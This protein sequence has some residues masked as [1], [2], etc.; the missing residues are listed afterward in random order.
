MWPKPYFAVPDG[1]LQCCRIQINY[2][3][4]GVV[5]PVELDAWLVYN[6]AGE[7]AKYDA[8]FRWFAWTVDTITQLLAANSQLGL[9][10]QPGLAATLVDQICA[11]ND[12]YC[13][14]SNQQYA[15]SSDCTSFLSSIEIG[16]SYQLGFNTLACRSLHIHMLP[17]RP[18][19]HCPHIGE[20]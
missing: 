12:Q 18:S 1:V 13:T 14:G 4:L 20:S 16:E 2:T 5:L 6:D 15:N 17:L 3:A 19:V 9:G 7:L 10:V 11:V 8:T